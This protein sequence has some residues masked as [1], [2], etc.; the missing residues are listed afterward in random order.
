M[1]IDEFVKQ[2]RESVDFGYPKHYQGQRRRLLAIIEAQ[3]AEL[4]RAQTLLDTFVERCDGC[5]E[6]DWFGDLEGRVEEF[7]GNAAIAERFER[8]EI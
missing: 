2:A 7:G 5:P 6:R 1:T 8:G 3:R 4:W